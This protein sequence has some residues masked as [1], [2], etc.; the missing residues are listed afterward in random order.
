MQLIVRILQIFACMDK[1]NYKVLLSESFRM[2]GKVC[3][4]G[5]YSTPTPT[6][7]SEGFFAVYVG[8]EQRR[9]VIPTHYLN[10]PF[11]EFLLKKSEEEFGF[12]LDGGLVIPCE[13]EHFECLLQSIKE[14]NS[15]VT[16]RKTIERDEIWKPKLVCP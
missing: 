6:D 2:D 7:I 1:S 16:S 13:V 10:H 15:L 8:K 12:C 5:P 14:G 11:F 9:F 3:K 4:F